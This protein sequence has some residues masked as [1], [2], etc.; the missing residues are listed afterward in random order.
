M[1]CEKDDFSDIDIRGSELEM[2]AVDNLGS[3][4]NNLVFDIL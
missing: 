3:L 1:Q 4:N 2:R